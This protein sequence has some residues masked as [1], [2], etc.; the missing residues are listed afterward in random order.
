MT[1]L[2][3]SRR[4]VALAKHLSADVAELE[5]ERDRYRAALEEISECGCGG[6]RGNGSC[7]ERLPVTRHVWCPTCLAR[8]ALG[9]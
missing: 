8:E 9:R 2:S 3:D 1:L 4:V 5:T 6:Y 7:R